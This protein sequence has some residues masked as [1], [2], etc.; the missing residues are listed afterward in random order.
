V[1]AR[2]EFPKAKVAALRAMALDSTL[3][4]AHTSLGFIALFYDWDWPAADRA[5][6]N[7]LALDSTYTPALL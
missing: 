3:P 5:F 1:A 6:R 2:G 7:A 4:E